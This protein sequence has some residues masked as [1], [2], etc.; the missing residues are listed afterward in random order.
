[1]EKQLH[2]EGIKPVAEIIPD[3]LMFSVIYSFD[4]PPGVSVKRFRPPHHRR[5][6]E[7]TEK[8]LSDEYS[9]GYGVRG[10][11][12]RGKHRKYAAVLTKAE[13][14][15]F[16]RHLMLAPEC[17]TMGMI[18]AP[19]FGFSATP[20]YCFQGGDEYAG[21]SLTAYVFPFDPAWVEAEECPF[22]MTGFWERTVKWLHEAYGS[23]SEFW[24][25]V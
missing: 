11:A 24:T 17:E 12:A 7:L 20:A 21:V 18:G 13:F 25:A 8:G 15:E 10:A 4:T 22:D 23:A 6:W 2:L 19:G 3:R 1:M 16:I 5:P 9:P 14:E